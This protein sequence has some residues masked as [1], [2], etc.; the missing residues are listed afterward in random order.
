MHKLS[1]AKS[2]SRGHPFNRPS[3]NPSPIIE[4]EIE[5]EVSFEKFTKPQTLTSKSVGFREINVSQFKRHEGNLYEASP[6][7]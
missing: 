3:I 7:L 5:N 4:H 2:S 1:I 6:E